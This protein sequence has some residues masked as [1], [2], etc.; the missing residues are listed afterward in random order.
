M[1]CNNVCLACVGTW[2]I[3]G[4]KRGMHDLNRNMKI[5]K[6][7]GKKKMLGTTE[8]LKRKEVIAK[9]IGGL[10]RAKERVSG[11]KNVAIEASKTEVER[12]LEGGPRTEQ[13]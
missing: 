5:L 4:T 2:S 12:R 8:T 13:L 11:L 1:Q 7:K 9:F 3:L 10:D 6:E